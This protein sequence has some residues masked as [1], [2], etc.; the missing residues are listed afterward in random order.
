[1]SSVAVA[2][3]SAPVAAVTIAA[4][5]PAASI[6]DAP[7]SATEIL[8]VIVAQKLKKAINEVP[9][10]KSIK[11]LVGGKSTLQ[12]EI[13]GGLQLE[14]SSAP[15]KGKELPLEELGSVLGT[16]F[17][18]N[19]GKHTTAMV[20]RLIGG[21]MP[22]GFNM[23]AA[24]S[25]LSKRWGLGSLRA[26]GILLL[27][28]TV[29]PPKRLGSEAEAKAWL[30]NVVSIY[31]QR[32]GIGLAMASGAAGAASSGAVTTINSKEFIKFQA[33]Q[34]RFTQQHIELYMCYLKRDS[35]AGELAFN[36]EKA[37][38]GTLQAKLDS[39]MK[40]HGDTYIDGI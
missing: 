15:E 16:G 21:K 11:D 29:E 5:G 12:N 18:G 33:E 3:V 9:M 13:L 25:Y 38:S 14:F 24:K 34:E 35:R 23:S 2:V 1:P 4:A 6:E 7:I 30:D 28:T 10:S 8:T 37:N 31:A 17:G 19:L 26:D 27:G 40:E 32:T 36:A 20:S 39:I 22:G